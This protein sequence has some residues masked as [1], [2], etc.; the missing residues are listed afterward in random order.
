MS[1]KTAGKILKGIY[2]AAI[3]ALGMLST[4]LVGKAS[5]GDVTSGQW[6]TILLFSLTAFGG[7]FGL[8]AWAGPTNGSG[9]P[10]A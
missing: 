8:S 10:P 6:V 2:S 5:F 3:A 1:Q 4:I 7:T 9:K